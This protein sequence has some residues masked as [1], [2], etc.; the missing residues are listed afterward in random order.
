MQFDQAM[1]NGN[2]AEALSLCYDNASTPVPPAA[3]DSVWP[4]VL[5]S[6]P[7]SSPPNVG[8]ASNLRT[9]AAAY[10]A[11]MNYCDKCGSSYSSDFHTCPDDDS[12]PPSASPTSPRSSTRGI[13]LVLDNVN[14]RGLDFDGI[15]APQSRTMVQTATKSSSGP[16]S[17][18]LSED[19]P[20]EAAGH[21]FERLRA[22]V[23]SN[24]ASEDPAL[25]EEEEEDPRR[26]EFILRVLGACAIM[27]LVIVVVSFFFTARFESKSDKLATEAVKLSTQVRDT[28]IQKEITQKLAVLKG[29]AIQVTVQDGIATLAGQAGSNADAAQAAAFALQANGVKAV[30]NNIKVDAGAKSSPDKS[31]Q[32]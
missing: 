24:S 13:H 31:T 17:L 25:A 6:E 11:R 8:A 28:N 14:D 19:I 26:K 1:S 4:S 23:E 2:Y 3:E 22:I 27:V 7:Q 21:E 30:T 20:S 32:H 12:S 10:A 15:S 5:A 18:P 16:T 29:S 9:S